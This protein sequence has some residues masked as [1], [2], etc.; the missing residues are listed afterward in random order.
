MVLCGICLMGFTLSTLIDVATR[1]SGDPLLFLQEVTSAFFI[2]GIFIG[3]AAATRRNDHL[4]LSA[5][6]YILLV[7]VPFLNPSHLRNVPRDFVLAGMVCSLPMI[8]IAAAS[9]PIY[10]VF[11]AAIAFTIFVPEAVL[12]LPRHVFPESVGC[13]KSPAGTGYICP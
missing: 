12:W 13:F 6:T 11:F 8:T 9:L 3:T 1:E 5:I 2:Y 10:L 4:F 7:V